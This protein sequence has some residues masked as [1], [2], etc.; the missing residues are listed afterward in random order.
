MQVLNSKAVAIVTAVCV[1]GLSGCSALNKGSQ[2]AATTGKPAVESPIYDIPRLEKIAIDGNADDWG[3][4]GFCVDMLM[5]I[6]LMD[7]DFKA[8]KFKPVSDFDVRIRLAWNDGGLLL[9][10]FVNDNTWI[11]SADINELYINDAVEVFLARQPG[12]QDLCQWVIAPGMAA[13]QPQ[14]RWHYNELR[15]NEVLKKLPT[16]LQAARTKTGNGYVMEVL[17]PW[18]ALAI[19]PRLN[20]EVAFQCWFDDKD[21]SMPLYRPAWYPA[22][23]TGSNSSRMNRLRLAIRPSTSISVAVRSDIDW[24]V[25]RIDRTVTARAEMAGKPVTLVEGNKVVAKGTLALDE[26]GHAAVRAMVSLPPAGEAARP[27][28]VQV[29]GKAAATLYPPPELSRQCAEQFLWQEPV[30]RP[31]VFSGEEFPDIDFEQPMWMRALVGSY[32]LDITF[33][34]KDYN[35]VTKAEEPG[36]YGAVVMITTKSGRPQRRFVTLYRTPDDFDLGAMKVKVDLALPEEMGVKPDALAAQPEHVA[37]F[38]KWTMID[39]FD[40]GLG[41]SFVAGMAEAGADQKDD[42]YSD[43][44]QVDRQWWLGLKRKLYGWDRQFPNAFVC[45]RPFEGKPAPVIREGTPEEAGMKP[46]AADKIDAVCK[47]WAADSDEAFAVCVARHGV[48]VL[49]KAYGTRDGKPMTVTTPSWMASITKMLS[50]TLMM[51]LVDQ[52]MISL[53]D[54]ADKYLPPLREIQTSRPITIRALYNHTTGMQ[55]HWGDRAND[56]EE[57][58]TG[59]LPFYKIGEQY[60]YN[61]TDMALACKILEAVSGESLPNFARRHLMG[62]LGCDHTEMNTASSDAHSV[63]LDMARIGQMLL[64]RGA[65]GDKRFFSEKTL[66]QML[67]RKLTGV[68]NAESIGSYGVATTWNDDDG[69]LAKGSFSHG[70]ASAATIRIDPVDDLVIVMCRNSAGKHFDEHHPQFI[71]AIVDGIKDRPAT[72]QPVK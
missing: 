1:C 3:Q 47:A 25:L 34:D 62:P 64:N 7:D 23:K 20:D 6:V 54:R 17:L 2:T 44:V 35:C 71:Q 24:P 32:R 14:L 42:S 4:Q 28:I 66:E 12:A 26:T 15:R 18:R 63:P 56:M 37:E 43:P 67:P 70:A 69:K 38:F 36:R 21:P 61:G 10:A 22:L 33:Y 68:P 53:D 39:A 30:A 55:W 58:M 51:M 60:L 31:A 52:G 9:L 13:D 50:G 72:G 5:P 29:A 19:A 46:D 40:R 57:R 11:E 65:Y 45:P 8:A 48:I 49:H 27:Q 41:A 16:D 59:V